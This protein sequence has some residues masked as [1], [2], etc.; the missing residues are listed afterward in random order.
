M[1]MTS[2]AFDNRQ[3]I[4]KR[5]TTDGKDISPP[6]EWRDIPKGTRTF[7]LICDDP[8]APTPE[9][10]VHPVAKLSGLTLNP[11]WVNGSEHAPR[12]RM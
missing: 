7:V 1:L 9:P 5:N 10:W 6:L 2:S 11:G 3:P 8:D 12:R 4:P